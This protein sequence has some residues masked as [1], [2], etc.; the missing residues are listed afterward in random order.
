MYFHFSKWKI[1]KLYYRLPTDLIKILL[2]WKY[3]QGENYA[4]LASIF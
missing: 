4:I 3:I 2:K 1:L